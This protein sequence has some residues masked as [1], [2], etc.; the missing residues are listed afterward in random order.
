MKKSFIKNL[1][2]VSIA[3]V[4]ALTS[5]SALAVEKG[6]WLVRYGVVNVSPDDSSTGLSGVGPTATVGVEDDTQAFANISYMIK[7]NVALELLAATPFSH[8]IVGTGALAGLGK[9]G[10]TKQLPPTFSIQ[11]HFKPK[12]SVRPYVGAGINYTVFFSEKATNTITSLKLD[13]SLGLAVQAGVD[14]DI[15]KN[16][17]FNA[18]IRYINIETT[19]TTDLGTSEVKINPTVISLGVGT[20]F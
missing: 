6:D 4:L 2:N 12:A 14:V 8:D 20:R 17:F 10:E 13:S 3:G 11:Y 1:I 9:V 5:V 15:N 7:D 18:D 19:A 16:W